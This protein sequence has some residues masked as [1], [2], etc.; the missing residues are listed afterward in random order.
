MSLYVLMR[1]LESAPGRY[2]TGIRLLTWGRLDRAYDRLTAHIQPGQ[3]VLDIGCGTGALA[4][5]AARQGAW[6]KG[7]DINPEM[8]AIARRRA[9][10]SGCEA[11][12]EW[13]EVGVAELDRE[14]AESWDVVTSGLCLSELSPDERDYTLAEI[15]R[16]LRPGG[17]LLVADEVRPEGRLQRW[18]QALLRAPLVALSYLLTQQTTRPIAALPQRLAAAGFEVISQRY[19]PS[20][21]FVELVARKP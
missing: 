18:I 19:S 7:I 4:L 12:V 6:V 15:R 13:E 17:L 3:R 2:D 20:G 10:E 11:R 9:R 21:D 16:L 1:L 14:A 8:L 5:R